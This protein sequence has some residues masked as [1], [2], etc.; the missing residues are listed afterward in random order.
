MANST[1]LTA[2]W[3]TAMF[4]VLAVSMA[5]YMRQSLKPRV[6]SLLLVSTPGAIS[7]LRHV[8]LPSEPGQPGVTFFEREVG[9]MHGGLALAGAYADSEREVGALA[10]VYAAYYFCVAVL[11]LADRARRDARAW[12]LALSSVSLGGLYTT[13]AVTAAN[14]VK[15][16]E[17][18]AGPPA[19]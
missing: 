4:V 13:V 14:R 11:M 9:L 10:T 2:T 5:L 3:Y 18:S 15:E 1:A 6:A 17:K 8:A 7:A 19:S 16:G 12:W